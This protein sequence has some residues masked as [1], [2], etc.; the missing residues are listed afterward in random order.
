MEGGKKKKGRQD[1]KKEKALF[2]LGSRLKTEV[3]LTA[4]G[5]LCT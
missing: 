2:S 3:V 5:I 4:G 1:K